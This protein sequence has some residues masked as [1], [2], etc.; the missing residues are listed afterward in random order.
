[1]NVRI[2]YWF[3]DWSF[4]SESIKI[5]SLRSWNEIIVQMNDPVYVQFVGDIIFLILF[6]AQLK[7]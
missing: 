6:N 7:H 3:V 5:L 4:D 1:M 2:V